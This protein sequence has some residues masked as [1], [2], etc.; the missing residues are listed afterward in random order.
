P[1]RPSKDVWKPGNLAGAIDAVDGVVRSERRS[2]HEQF[3]GRTH[4][5]V[6]R[7]NAR[8]Q[9]GERRRLAVAHPKDRTGAIA[10]VEPSLTVECQTACDAQVTCH[11]L[12]RSV[13]ADAINS[14]LEA[15]RDVQTV[16]GSYGHWRP[17][18]DGRGE[19]FASG[20]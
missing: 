15:A 11:N 14:A 2:S 16:I 5:Q 20:P 6:K 4:R 1:L 10:D 18:R 8:G 9:R 12:M 13:A 17:V 7:G 19:R 3:V